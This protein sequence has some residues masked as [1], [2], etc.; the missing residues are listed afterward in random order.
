[1]EMQLEVSGVQIDILLIFFG[2]NSGDF[3]IRRWTFFFSGNLS[4]S[5]WGFQGL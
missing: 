5:R 2:G 1:M 3:V 4:R